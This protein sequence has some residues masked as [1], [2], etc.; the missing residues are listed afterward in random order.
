[1]AVNIALALEHVDFN[2]INITLVDGM[3][4]DK[5]K[6]RYNWIFNASIEDAIIGEDNYGLV[7][8]SG[9]WICGDWY[10]GTWYSGNFETGT[11]R[12]GRFYSYKLNK[13]D[14]LNGNFNIIDRGNQYSVMGIGEGYVEWESGDFYGGTFGTKVIDWSLYTPYDPNN[15][16]GN[17]DIT[18]NSGQTC[19]WRNGNFY[20]GVIFNSIWWD[21][22]WYNGYME[23]I[24]W[25]SGK[26]YNGEF[27]GYIWY[28]GTFLG[29]DFINGEW[30]N[31][32][33]TTFNENVK[34][35]F[36]VVKNPESFIETIS[37]NENTTFVKPLT[38]TVFG[39]GNLTWLNGTYTGLVQ[40]INQQIH[41]SRSVNSY[42]TNS[43]ANSGYTQTLSIN[44]WSFNIP[45]TATINGIEVYI[46]LYASYKDSRTYKVSKVTLS[47]T[48][49]NNPLLQSNNLAGNE[50]VDVYPSGSPWPPLYYNYFYGSPT[51]TWG[52]SFTPEDVNSPLFSVNFKLLKDVTFY[53]ICYFAGLVVNVYYT[54]DVSTYNYEKC[55]WN[56]GNFNNGEFHSG[57]IT[58][59][60]GSITESGNHKISIWNNGNFNNGK[61]YGG[62]FR[63]GT[64][65]NGEFLAGYFGTD[66]FAPTWN[67]GQFING[68]WQNGVFNN[69][70][71]HNGICKNIDIKN[72][73]LGD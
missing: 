18:N 16:Q 13:Y 4:I 35:R 2:K 36:G 52:M 23:N 42:I 73:K 65:N 15:P 7:W 71:F 33:F 37:V 26:F 47:K 67:N 56:N 11:W 72:G 61:W 53:N 25:I 60:D 70:E 43:A 19:V 68:F 14:V 10:D 48:I 41:Q 12:N 44:G 9:N 5:L 8:Y 1:M 34:S 20:N 38:Y 39:G 30:M 32:V 27:N 22:N 50:L 62:S 17:N 66:S 64:F 21:G 49:T 59:A 29:G 40:V 3:S 31:G 58:N 51:N 28:N 69:G 54:T 57:L 46:S 24:Q 63:N 45:E 6:I 55:T